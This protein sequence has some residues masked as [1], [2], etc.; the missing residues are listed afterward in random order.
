MTYLSLNLQ[1]FAG[2]KTEKATPKKRRDTRK[3]G[4]TAKSQDINTAIVLLAVFLF[5]Y[6][7]AGTIGKPMSQLV[8]TSLTEYMLQDVTE[9]SIHKIFIEIVKQMASML[10]PVMAVAF[11]AGIVANLAQTGFIFT[12]EGLKPSLGKLNPLTGIKRIL[13]IRAL[14]ELLKSELKMMLIGVVAFSVLWTNI[15]DI[16]NLPFKS[17]AASLQVVGHL[18]LSIGLASSIALF[19]LAIL[20]YLYQ[21]FDFEK[22]IR[23]SKQD[24]KDEFKNTEGDPFIKSKIR[25][26]QKEMAMKRMMQEVPD[27]D[28]VITNPTHYAIC[29]KYDETKSDAPLVIA[30]G[31]D[32][33]AQKIKEIAR[34]NDIVMM[35]NR[36]LARALYAQVEVGDVIPE[37]FFK[38]VAEI[39]AYVYKMKHKI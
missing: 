27:A 5:L 6:F 30:K 11:I 29:L 38:A 1:Y 33:L 34:E 24:I 15:S 17:A 10:V 4:Q 13:S 31:A 20:D 9:Q 3:K 37:Q 32:Y 35:E 36:P 19:A 12:G 18:T 22:N 23:M 7:G 21:R 28:V 14:V 2:E 26:K 16:L 25:Q 8:H 39:L